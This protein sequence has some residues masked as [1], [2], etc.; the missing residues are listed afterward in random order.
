MGQR[1][2]QKIIY[3]FDCLLC[4]IFP[5]P[6]VCQICNIEL[7]EEDK[8][9]CKGCINNLIKIDEKIKIKN[10]ENIYLDECIA[11]YEFKGLARELVHDLKYKGKIERAELMAF[12]MDK[13]IK[14]DIDIITSVPQSKKTHTKRGYNQSEE[15]S[16][17]ISKRIG[18]EY[19]KLL[20]R[21]KETKSQVLLDGIDRWYNVLD[22]F[23]AEY[24]LKGK[25]VLIVDDVITTG[26][27]LNF[28]AKALKQKGASQVYG[29]CFAK[30]C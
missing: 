9:I 1:I 15:I 18:V 6:I 7:G 26:A 19:K 27:T 24:D 22:A 8:F 11:I 2:L 14:Y 12:L 21:T 25:R 13:N 16:R 20:V 29:V 3:I 28:C 10:G 5:E 30:T 4:V 17:H 23:C